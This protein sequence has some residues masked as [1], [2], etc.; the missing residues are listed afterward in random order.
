MSPMELIEDLQQRVADLPPG[1]RRLLDEELQEAAMSEDKP[2][3]IRGQLDLFKFKHL[4]EGD[5]D[6]KTVSLEE[7]SDTYG[8]SIESLKRYIRQ[9]ALTAVQFGRKYHI[10]ISELK[11]FLATPRRSIGRGRRIT[12]NEGSSK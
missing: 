12:T 2:I 9:G 8:V 3:E 5:D 11:R 6:L 1:R 4:V 7:I 10:T